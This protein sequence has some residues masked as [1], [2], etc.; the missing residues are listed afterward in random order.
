MANAVDVSTPRDA[1]L[2]GHLVD[3]VIG[4]LTLTTGILFVAL[5]VVLAATL[6]FFRERAKRRYAHYTHGDRPRDHVLTFAVALTIF[7]AVDVTLAVRA[8]R[9]LSD[10]FWRY[11][12]TQSDALRV[13]VM[14]RQWSWT[15]RTAGPD[16]RFGTPDD[17]VTLN[18][19]NVPV[20]R[21]VYLKL[22]SKDVVH[23]LYLPNF[24]T[25]I[26]A[27]PGTTTRLW[28]QA[29]EPGQYEIGCAQHCG[30]SHYKMRGVLV[31][32]TPQ[33][34]QG[35]LTRAEVDARLRY[36]PADTEAHEGW[37]WEPGQ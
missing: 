29:M 28:F 31:A 9:D 33:D 4:Y 17:V 13:E 3:E 10:R 7:V 15:F 27:I 8:S 30:V 20:G 18:Q 19:L 21:P 23:S 32:R 6:L 16:A 22:R 34:H 37:P 26:D 25:K 11:P 1:S 12:D 5:V 35:W 2:D 36:D 14:A 24:R